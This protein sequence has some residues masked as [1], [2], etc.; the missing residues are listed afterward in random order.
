MLFKEVLTLKGNTKQRWL[1]VC[2]EAAVCDEPERLKQL[3]AEIDAVLREEQ[4]RLTRD[5]K[6]THTAA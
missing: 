5:L 4:E 1:D 3:T 2:S 6:G